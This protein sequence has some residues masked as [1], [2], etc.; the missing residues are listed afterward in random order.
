MTDL[1]PTSPPPAPPPAAPQDRAPG[2]ARPLWRKAL[3]PL[4]VLSCGI[5][6]AIAITRSA[7]QVDRMTPE[8]SATLVEVTVVERADTRVRVPAM[9]TVIPAQDLVLKSRVAGQVV[10]VHPEFTD[11]G[12]IRAGEEI[13]R[14]EPVDYELAVTR[15]QSALAEAEYQ[16]KLEQ[17]RQDVA[18]REWELL[19]EEAGDPLDGDLALRRPHLE[20]AQ[21]D[22][23][24][25]R[26]DLAQARL[27]LARTRIEAPFNALVRTRRVEQGSQVA[28][29]EQLAELVGTD[30]YWIR[31]TLPVDRLQWV[32]LP[33]G[34]GEAGAAVHVTY[35]G[36]YT[37]QGQV[38]R[39]LGDLETE[40]RLARVL[41]AVSDPLD[42]TAPETPRPPLLIGEYV[43]LEIE[44]RA[45]ENVL[46][47][48]RTAL[49]DGSTIWVADA[50]DRLE[51]RPVDPL[52]R[53]TDTV[54]LREGL[55][56]GERL[57][58]SE[59]PSPV[60]GMALRIQP[61][62][63]APAVSAQ[64]TPN[65]LPPTKGGS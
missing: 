1:L 51:V 44:G 21:A 15:R 50:Q 29:Q 13:L 55:A 37:R 28:A 25:A 33:R 2:P 36:G 40:G 14:I 4:L 17:G 24:A 20:K 3:L 23:A 53:E 64:S 32:D 47:I 38:V 43:R 58:V 60:P 56:P 41:V 7:P 19:G 16:L 54:L 46:R 35:A 57:V 63:G 11:G 22:L 45:L 42:L 48:P 5:A 30:A 52:W 61:P 10:A 12:F 39:L 34:N 8:R 62:P 6:G 31:A 59:L 65:G 26:A 9:G 27:D 49:R 18:K